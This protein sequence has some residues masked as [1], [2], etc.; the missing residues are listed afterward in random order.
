VPDFTNPIYSELIHGAQEAADEAGYILLVGSA[1]ATP[2]DHR[3]FEK[4][5]DD[6]IVDG[7]LFAS[8][9]LEDPHLEEMAARDERI[10]I[11]NR[12]ISGGGPAVVLD[13]VAGSR[14]AT[15]H[16]IELG[17]R[18]IGAVAGP[19]RVETTERR[20][21]GFLEEATEAG[22]DKP[23]VILASTVSADAGYEAAETL[24]EQHP[25]LTAIFAT[26]TMIA[27]GVLK[28]VRASGR[29][30]PGDISLVV[31]NDSELARYVEPAL[32]TVA[33]PHHQLGRVAIQQLL[34]RLD[35]VSEA[36]ATMVNDPPPRL[37][38]RD[39]TAPPRSSRT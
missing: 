18:R 11:V 16:L 32:T 24:L 30:V 1:S 31:L 4:L 35:G 10:L 37:I 13:D 14:L 21:R 29:S 17:H 34:R 25:D 39:S 3:W 28:A 6:S 8:G 19:P 23:P 26:T 9:V 22:I 20:R 27:F 15:R 7:M 33:L 2:Q 12:L 5:L 36:G 38:V